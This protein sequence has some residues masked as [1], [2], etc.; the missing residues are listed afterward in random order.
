MFSFCRVAGLRSLQHATSCASPSQ[1]G[2]DYHL[3]LWFV[4]LQADGKVAAHPLQLHCSLQGQWSAREIT[5]EEN[6]MEVSYSPAQVC[7]HIHTYSM[8]DN[9]STLFFSFFLF[10]FLSKLKQVNFSGHI[11]GLKVDLSNL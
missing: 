8:S 2:A 7:H 5:C 3:R 10:S 11:L 1:R 4:N 6:Y 9:F